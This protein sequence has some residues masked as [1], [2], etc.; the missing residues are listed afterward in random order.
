M[1]SRLI[2]N[3]LPRKGLRVRVPCPPLFD[4]AAVAS[5][6]LF[7][8]WSVGSPVV[9]RQFVSVALRDMVSFAGILLSRKSHAI[10]DSI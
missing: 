6:E 8:R 9:G 10:C 5:A 1:A 7:L 2:R 4:E 3:Q